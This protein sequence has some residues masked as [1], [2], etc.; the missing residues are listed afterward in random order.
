MPILDSGYQ[1]WSG[2]LG[3]HAWRWLVITRHGVRIGLRNR[4]LRLSLIVAALPGLVL[5]AML[6][7]WGLLEQQPELIETLRPI[8]SIFSFLDARMIDEPRSYRVDVWTLSFSY[9]LKTQQWLSMVLIL[10]VGPSLISQDLRYNSLPLYLSRPVR[11]FDYFLGK[12]GVIVTFIGAVTV[13]PVIA[14]W[15]L[16]LLFS[17]DF[18]I[19]RDTF[20]LMLAGAAFGLLI[21]VSAGMLVLALSSLSRNSRYVALFWLAI[22]MGTGMVSMVLQG[23]D[24]EQR[25]HAWRG[26]EFDPDVFAAAELEAA[27][28]NWRPLT[29]YNDNLARIGQQLLGTDAVW[30]K[31]SKFHFGGE[32]DRFLYESRGPQYPWQ[33]S[34]MVLAAI[35]ALSAWILNR[36][37]RSLDRLK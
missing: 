15:V 1:H 33:W 18:S 26:R 29:S 13:V 34:A 28:R 16:G 6:C 4:W 5:V 11:R 32:R 23:I 25:Q 21:A 3:S 27:E 17:L 20:G 2:T 35:F 7:M 24:M 10:I 31:L 19:V 22:W 12:L 36:S 14:A 8:L 9:F 30:N 37:I